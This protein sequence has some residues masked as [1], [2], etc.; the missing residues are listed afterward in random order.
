M[1][2][3]GQGVEEDQSK[4]VEVYQE[5]ESKGENVFVF[6]GCGFPWLTSL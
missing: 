4:A 1:Y 5:G 2:K 6:L 3:T